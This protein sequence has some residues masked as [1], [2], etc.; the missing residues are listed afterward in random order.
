MIWNAAKNKWKNTGRSWG[1]EESVRCKGLFIRAISH[2]KSIITTNI[3]VPI[4][5]GVLK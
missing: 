5:Y 2:D 3:A 4:W 1:E